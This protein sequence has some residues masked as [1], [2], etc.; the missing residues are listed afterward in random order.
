MKFQNVNKGYLL[1]LHNLVNDLVKWKNHDLYNR[2]V[3]IQF[4]R[5]IPGRNSGGYEFCTPILW[6]RPE[7][8]KPSNLKVFLREKEREIDFKSISLA[9]SMVLMK[10]VI[11]HRLKS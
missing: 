8:I 3:R 10:L 6:G 9:V 11:L 7:L 1:Y 5:L 4:Q 2:A